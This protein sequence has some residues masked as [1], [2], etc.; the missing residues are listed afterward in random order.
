[1]IFPIMILLF[2]VCILPISISTTDC[3]LL[4]DCGHFMAIR[5]QSSPSS[6]LL[7]T[8][9]MVTNAPLRMSSAIVPVLIST[10]IS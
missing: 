6:H 2:L 9:W 8:P 4:A 5:I 7:S 3:L 10:V 1:M